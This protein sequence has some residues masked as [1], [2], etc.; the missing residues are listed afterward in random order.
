MKK[1][2]AIALLAVSTVLSPQAMARQGTIVGFDV[3]G[4]N[5]GTT[6]FYYQAPVFNNS[7]YRFSAMSNSGNIN[8]GLGF[9]F[10][11]DRYAA[12]PYLQGD[13]LFGNTSETRMQVGLDMPM[14]NIVIDP[15][16]WAGSG[17]SGVGL[18]LG[19]RL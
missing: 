18:N 6:N 3:L 12:S 11:I 4:L 5:N 8:L 10:Y 19:L 1:Y 7:A 16:L 2:F 17:N 13:L 9:R 14:G 15:H